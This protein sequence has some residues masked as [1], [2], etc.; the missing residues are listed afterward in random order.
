MSAVFLDFTVGF[1]SN[2]SYMGRH[3]AKHFCWFQL[4]PP[5]FSPLPF[6]PPFLLARRESGSFANSLHRHATE[7]SLRAWRR[8]AA[9]RPPGVR[10]V[11][12]LYT[13]DA[14]LTSGRKRKRKERRHASPP[15]R[16]FRITSALGP[17]LRVQPLVAVPRTPAAQCRARRR[18]KEAASV[19]KRPPTSIPRTTSRARLVPWSSGYW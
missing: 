3:R 5:L 14:S 13:R 12:T 19:L 7:C 4:V 15:Q 2:H 18:R 10:A 17:G 6:Y 8:Q 9:A 1:A 16:A 11:Q